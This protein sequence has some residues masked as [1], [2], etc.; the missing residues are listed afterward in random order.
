MWLLMNVL[1]I[2][3][4][5]LLCVSLRSCLMMVVDVIFMSSMWLSLIV[6]N[7]FLRVR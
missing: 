5:N 1:E 7:E 2:V 6:L 4:I 3:L